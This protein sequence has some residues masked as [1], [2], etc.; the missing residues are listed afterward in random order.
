MTATYHRRFFPADVDGTVPYVA[1]NDVRNDRD[2]YA[3]FLRRVGTDPQCRRDLLGVQRRILGPDRAWF[4]ERTRTAAEAAGETWEILGTVDRA[5][6]IAA[7]DLYFTFWQYSGQAACDG[8]P[9]AGATNDEIWAWT[10]GVVSL[11]GYMDST[12][13]FYAPYYYQAAYQLGWYRTLVGPLRDVLRY[14]NDPVAAP[15]LVPR[16]LRPVRFDRRRCPTST[17]GS[18]PSPPGC[19]SSTAGSTRGAP[20]RSGAGRRATPSAAGARC[21]SWRAAPTVPPSR[22]CPRPS[23]SPSPAASSAGRAWP[24]TTRRSPRC[25]APAR[26]G[27][28][29]GWTAPSRAG[30]ERCSVQRVHRASPGRG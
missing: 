30:S 17:A 22:S 2:A 25:S 23:G 18:A 5:M 4:R 10:E 29:A 8:V 16:E 28:R 26:R 19:S 9:A 6:E 11:T 27:R 3:S 24:P 15:R 21:T 1:P 12:L 13:E 7:M 20:S 14:G